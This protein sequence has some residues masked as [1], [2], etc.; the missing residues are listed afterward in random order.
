M[1]I[2]LGVLIFLFLVLVFGGL[3]V[4]RTACVRRKE[5]PWLVREVTMDDGEEIETLYKASFK[6]PE[7]SAT[8]IMKEWIANMT[9]T[10]DDGDE[11]IDD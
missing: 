8:G 3:Y 7:E 10:D 11:G 6:D 2:A 4:F 1:V 9:H 5:I